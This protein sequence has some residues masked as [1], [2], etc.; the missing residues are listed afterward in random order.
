MRALIV[1][2]IACVF[3]TACK[4]EEIIE[5]SSSTKKEEKKEEV[6]DT[7]TY[8][9]DA[10]INAAI[11][12]ARKTL[13]EFYKRLA[14]PQEGDNGFSLKVKLRDSNGEEECWFSKIAVEGDSLVGTLSNKP[15]TV[16]S[17]K[18]GMK[19]SIA[20]EDIRD[21]MYFQ[22]R[23][24]IGNLTVYPM[25]NALPPKEAYLMKQKLGIE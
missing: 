17:L 4:K 8:S 25:I 3:F 22:N 7:I 20:E 11:L 5:T 13:P 19:M 9:K 15:V 18:Q 6:K 23:K 10:E 14:A 12:E 24:M 21:W 16:T 2:L 1:L